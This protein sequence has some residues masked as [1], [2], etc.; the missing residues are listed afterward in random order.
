MMTADDVKTVLCHD[1]YRT[2]FE[3]AESMFIVSRFKHTNGDLINFHVKSEPCGTAIS[4]NGETLAHLSVSG[5]NPTPKF[6]RIIRAVCAAYAL[7]WREDEFLKPTTTASFGRDC[8]LMGQALTRISN[9]ALEVVHRH[10]L[11]VIDSVERLLTSS[12][13]IHQKVIKNWHHPLDITEFFDVNFRIGGSQAVMNKNIFIV[14]SPKRGSDVVATCLYLKNQDDTA[15]SL[16]VVGEKI[17]ERDVMKLRTVSKVVSGLNGHEEE[18]EEF[19]A[20]AQ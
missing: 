6:N 12:P 4:D 2:V 11:D 18:V 3:D 8:V 20:A 5:V 1:L 7:E 14:G 15:E 10:H 13:K 19:A 16:S 17:S 9:L